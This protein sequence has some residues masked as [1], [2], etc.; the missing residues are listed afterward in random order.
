[1][2]QA[3]SCYAGTVNQLEFF[4]LAAALG[5]LGAVI[6]LYRKNR[7]L[8][9]NNNQKQQYFNSSLTFT[10]RISPELLQGLGI[11]TFI[12][13]QDTDQLNLDP[14]A[15]F[16]LRLGGNSVQ[17]V[18]E[19]LD[20]LPQEQARKLNNALMVL[21][22]E[23]KNSVELELGS[24]YLWLHF[25][26]LEGQVFYGL[27]LDVS[28]LRSENTQFVKNLQVEAQF[29]AMAKNQFLSNMSHEIR[30]PMNGVIGIAELLLET[31]MN[32][33]QME[34]AEIIRHSAEKML[35]VINDLLDVTKLEANRMVLE[36]RPFMLS[37]V[38]K[39]S[40]EKVS[41]VA[42][43]KGLK[44]TCN[45]SENLGEEF[46]GDAFRLR[47]ILVNLLDNAVKFT[48]SGQVE[49]SC[50]KVKQNG[51]KVRLYFSVLDTGIGLKN[52]NMDVL[53]EPFYLAD[54]SNTRRYGGSGLGLPIVK[55]LT[56]LMNGF[57][58]A[59]SSEGGGSKFSVEIELQDGSEQ[60]L[61][62]FPVGPN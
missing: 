60:G 21:R 25:A 34:Y 55:R 38:L 17:T 23:S 59:E 28:S 35:T 33:E 29:A 1:M 22:A 49:L 12:W 37:V 31:D 4:M 26:R 54:Q 24:K 51:N 32:S 16:H 19:Y 48:D 11:G 13:N 47:Q 10:P 6:F 40:L 45:C 52:C 30:T 39:E 3:K 56:E 27:V 50:K 62:R 14:L 57:V 36:S 8:L 58:T 43:S 9:I 42:M 15:D 61:Q 7:L 18:K 5:L 2:K 53:F 20:M 46:V 44:L 41:N